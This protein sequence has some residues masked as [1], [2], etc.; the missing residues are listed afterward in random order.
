MQA[1]AIRGFI[2]AAVPIFIGI[3][4]SG[5]G[6]GGTT[7]TPTTTTVTTTTVTTTLKPS[8]LCIFDVD[9]TL[10]GAQGQETKCP[11]AKIQPNV[12]DNAYKGG[13]LMLSELAWKGINQTFC[14][15]CH[16]GIVSAGEVTGG[17]SPERAVIM[18]AVGPQNTTLTDKWQDLPTKGPFTSSLVLGWPDGTKQNAVKSIVEWF[19]REHKVYVPDSMVHFFDDR[20]N[21]I[22][23]FK[24]LPYNARQ[25]S[26]ASRDPGNPDLGFCGAQLSEIVPD[27][28]VKSCADL[29]AEQT[30][31]V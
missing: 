5:C 10:T 2:F 14:V 15:K 27:T 9:R 12:P 1:S 26:C 29:A 21:N 23:P 17:L 25:I 13:T 16:H 22:A 20:P 24:G 19:M 18:T 11:T 31:V 6:G 28:G 3:V 30:V 4:L 7:T 8:C